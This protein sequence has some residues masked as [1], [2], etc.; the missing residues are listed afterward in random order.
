MNSISL[1]VTTNQIILNSD[2]ENPNTWQDLYRLIP[3]LRNS[4]TCV[5]CG[6]LLV[7]PMTPSAA[8]CQHHLCRK[9]EGGRKRIKPACQLC[10]DCDSYRE[11]CQLRTLLQCYKRMCCML[12]SSTIYK[13]LDQSSRNHAAVGVERGAGNLISLVR[14]GAAFHDEYDHK[15][16]LTKSDISLLPCVYT[17]SSTQTL[18]VN[19]TEN[20]RILYNVNQN[21]TLYS[22][23]YAGTGGKIM[24]KRK[25]KN[26]LNDKMSKSSIM[27]KEETSEKVIYSQDDSIYVIICFRLFLKSLH[28]LNVP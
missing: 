20:Q 12:M 7:D 5:V 15:V 28:K 2:P 10:K 24:F 9:C 13:C 18:Q 17:N 23:L 14:E 6:N 16:G 11:N 19:Q 1:Y 27:R 25:P 26:V 3:Y 8:N 21:K 22:V 4:V